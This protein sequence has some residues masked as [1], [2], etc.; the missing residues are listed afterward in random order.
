MKDKL[1]SSEFL[2]IVGLLI[3]MFSTLLV[4]LMSYVRRKSERELTDRYD[5]EKKMIELDYMRKNLEM[6]LYDVSKKL[7]E[8]ESRWKDINHLVISS[9]NR[10][11]KVNYNKS[12]VEP[13]D[14]L[15]NLGIESARDF[16]VDTRQVFVLT[17]FNPEFQSTFYIIKNVC[18]N[19]RLR[20]IRG[21]E[22]F[23]PNEIFPTILKQIV[24][25]RL[26][27]ANITGRNP[28]VMYELG[29]AH[30]IGKPTIII[31]KNFT[32]IPF[33]L[34]NKR[35]IIYETEKDLVNKLENSIKDML[36][37]KVL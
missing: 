11:E 16:E 8:T 14:F 6:Q 26:I 36:I 19:L 23:I 21:D 12:D 10:L 32:E 13:N 25:S 7:E 15:K 37:N 3:V 29:V 31:S 27:I 22:D 17:P 33:D 34:N 28:N 5:T 2:I 20:C 4:F 24:Q 1:M 9:Q 35:I 18:E 30:A